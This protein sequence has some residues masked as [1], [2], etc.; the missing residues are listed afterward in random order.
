MT[1]RRR[2]RRRADTPTLM[3]VVCV[4]ARP[5]WPPAPIDRLDRAM[6]CCAAAG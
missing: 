1:A 2:R 5:A 4:L 3:R 6:R